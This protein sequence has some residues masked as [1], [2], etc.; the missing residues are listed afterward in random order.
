MKFR[1]LTIL[2]IVFTYNSCRNDIG[3]SS[4]YITQRVV[5]VVVDGPRYQETWNYK[6]RSFISNRNELSKEGVLFTNFKNTGITLTNPGHTSIVTGVNQNI[7]NAGAQLPDQ[8]SIFQYYLKEKVLPNSACQ[9]IASK[10]KLAV[11]SNCLNLTYK[12]KF[13]P[14]YNCG[15]S[16]LNS[17]YREDKET[18]KVALQTLANKHPNLVLIQF[19]EPDASGHANDWRGYVNGIQKTDEYIGLIWKYLQE[20]SYFFGKTSLFVTNDHGRHDD[21]VSNGFVNHGDNCNGCRHIELLA[22]GPDFS[23]GKV[24]SNSYNQTDLA[25]TIGTILGFKSYYSQGK[26]IQELLK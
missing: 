18:F 2:F 16:G 1:I 22:I 20:D 8:P 6:N 26:T 12:N 14:E 15:I 23:K 25:S 10:D 13:M 19:K 17:G 7:N 9:I 11:L 3:I 24:I 21:N 5:I 4:K